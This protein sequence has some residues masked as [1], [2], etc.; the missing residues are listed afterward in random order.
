[1]GGSN[2]RNSYRIGRNHELRRRKLIELRIIPLRV[3]MH[4]QS[5]RIGQCTGQLN[6]VSG[7]RIKWRRH[8]GIGDGANKSIL[9]FDERFERRPA[10]H[11]HQTRSSMFAGLELPWWDLLLRYEDERSGK[12]H[13]RFALQW[14]SARISNRCRFVWSFARLSSVSCERFVH[15]RGNDDLSVSCESLSEFCLLP[16][17]W[18]RLSGQRFRCA[19]ENDDLD[20]LL[21]ER[22]DS[23]FERDG[24]SSVSEIVL[25]FPI[26]S[27]KHLKSGWLLQIF[28]GIFI[29]NGRLESSDSRSLQR[30]LTAVSLTG[31]NCFKAKSPWHVSPITYVERRVFAKRLRHKL[32]QGMNL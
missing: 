31:P 26:F 22:S 13:A 29:T 16:S 20:R 25:A 8:F 4:C 3:V 30:V 32:V 1:M 12:M 27:R 7:Q 15:E 23:A 28:A 2:I 17:L 11:E 14:L 18:Q 9:D 21:F 5:S 19:V 6:G 24:L 10:T